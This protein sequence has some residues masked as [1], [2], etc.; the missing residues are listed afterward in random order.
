M[1][2]MALRLNTCFLLALVFTSVLWKTS[3]GVPMRG[4]GL[5]DRTCDDLPGLNVSWFYTWLANSPCPDES[6]PPFVPMI[7]KADDMQY[8]ATINQTSATHLLGF[9][10]PDEP[11][12][13]DMTVEEAIELWPQ[14]METG[15]RLGSPAATQYTNSKG[16]GPRWLK[17]FMGNVTKLGYRVDFICIHYYMHNTGSYTTINDL[18]AFLENIESSYPGYKVWLTEFN[19][20]TGDTNENIGYFKK[21]YNLITTDFID[22]VERYSWFTN[23]W[24]EGTNQDTFLNDMNTGELTQLGKVYAS[25]PNH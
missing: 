23:R 4:V 1:N 24:S 15:L 7:F 12:Q 20:S 22:L 25:Y 16:N 9:N 14:L 11:N 13:A 17:D 5:A 21:A 8:V 18:K 2:K 19:N 6:T 10:E 3:M